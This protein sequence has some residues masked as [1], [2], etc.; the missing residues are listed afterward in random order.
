MKVK[1]LSM[2]LIVSFLFSMFACSKSSTDAG[3]D[4]AAQ[5][6]SPV[7]TGV[8]DVE[9][10]KDDL[11]ELDFGGES[12][13]I[14][15][16]NIYSD[17]GE[18]HRR[19]DFTIEELSS[20]AINDSLYNRERYVEDRL[21]VEINNPQIVDY[22]VIEE[23]R[24]NATSGDD[25]YDAYLA[26]VSG[27]SA[28]TFEEYLVDLYEMEYLDF[29]KPWWSEKFNS[30]AEFLDSL[31]MTTGSLSL[32]PI[33]YSYAVYYNKA[34]AERYES[35]IEELGNLYEIVDSGKWTFDKFAELGSEIYE[36]VNGNSRRDLEDIYGVACALGYPIDAIWSSFDLNVFSRTSDGW[37]ELDV[38]TDK[39]YTALD[40]V[41]ELLH[42]SVGSITAGVGTT[43]ETMYDFDNI[44]REFASGTNLFLVADI[45]RAEFE[46]LRNM[47]DDYGILP[48]PKYNE[49][50]DDYYTFSHAAYT[51][52]AIPVTNT[53]PEVVCAVLEAMA[54][55]AYRDTMPTYLNTV[56]K[57][58]YMSDPESRRMI[59]KVV[60]GFMVDA[61]WIYQ[62][63]SYEYPV[64]YRYMVE[65]NERSYAS[66]HA[67]MI[68]KVETLLKVYKT[69]MEK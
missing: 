61:A 1:V 13:T 69:Q 53:D 28:F 50:Q 37:Y 63:L 48:Y 65:K 7:T 24:K 31:Y 34:L 12:V 51:V 57:G 25:V 59:D 52:F 23:M 6:T 15:S 4:T 44:E 19:P 49:M 36:D 14:L 56:L 55:Y 20:D 9:Y 11:P 10:I 35:S 42:N 60:D 8:P 29:D 64:W 21:G 16:S 67:S 66:Q 47:Q 3:K 43:E 27:V 38:N 45:V 40:K 62:T 33:R 54:S 18:V 2:L 5:T 22:M 58:Q 46:E 39:L 26:A 30:E 17:Q 41:N 68:K 32:T